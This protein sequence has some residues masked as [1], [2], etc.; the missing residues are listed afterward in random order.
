MRYL[1]RS[2]LWAA[3]AALLC[4]SCDVP[5]EKTPHQRELEAE[6]ERRRQASLADAA[7]G[8]ADDEAAR[9][10]IPRAETLVVAID[11]EPDHLNPLLRIS[12][13]GR[14]IA[15][16]N[17]FE[18]L[19]RR[20][21]ETHQLRPHLATSWTV[22][23]DGKVYRFTLR[24]DVRWHDGQELTSRDV[25][26]SLGRIHDPQTPMEPFRSDLINELHQVDPLTPQE[27]RITLARPNS[28]LLDHLCEVPILPYHLSGRTINTSHPLSR[29]PVGTGPFRFQ[30][31]TKAK[32]IRLARNERYWGT[33][34]A[35]GEVVF[36]LIPDPA[37]A[38]T[39]LKRGVVD[40]LPEVYRQHYPDQLTAWARRRFQEVWFSP[41]GFR[42]ILWN[43]RNPMLSDFRVRR[44][45]TMLI[46]RPRIIK[47]VYR[48]LAVPR[49]GPFWHPAGLG[50]PSV[51]PWPFDPVR[52]RNLLDNA[53]WRDRDGDKIRDLDDRALRITLLRP[54]T[55]TVMDDELKVI[56][57]EFKQS[58]VELEP[59]QT[60][61]RRMQQLLKSGK[62]MAAAI[63][64]SGRPAEDLSILFHSAGSQ[65]YG[66][67]GS[68]ATDR[69]LSDMRN[70]LSSRRRAEYSKALE[71]ALWASQAVTFLHGPKILGLLHR[72]FEGVVMS[73]EWL[74]LE[75]LRIAPFDDPIQ[76]GVPIGAAGGRPGEPGPPEPAPGARPQMERP[77][78]RPGPSEP[79]PRARPQMERPVFRPGPG[80]P[81]RSVEERVMGEPM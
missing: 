71:R 67:S 34:P 31:W 80:G 12:T 81:A 15:L 16:Y 54:V 77:A 74:H 76:G 6:R 63:A 60:D 8:R 50:D 57:A 26:Y 4:G 24:K 43:T 49:V 58:G 52:A 48:E 53:G 39:D 30:S 59:V 13:W 38:L 29:K 56:T 11:E 7:V 70:A 28:Y 21:P 18:T 55:S 27:V 36:R 75:R 68:L 46:N 51:E 41:P 42:M 61:W 69:L 20:D 66:K 65:N 23:A 78:L 62:F 22:S 14:R 25:W 10:A 33:V 3:L 2:A 9:P 32:E 19:L 40:L 35:V 17:V 45:F 79:A 72:R 44:A 37:K 64:W 47:E 73:S 1:H 5:R